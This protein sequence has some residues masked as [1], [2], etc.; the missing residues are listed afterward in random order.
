MF[1]KKIVDLSLVI[2]NHTPIYPGDPEPRLSVATTIAGEGYNLHHVHIGSQTGSHVDAPYHFLDSG[3]RI[4]EMD[5][6]AFV[7]PGLLIPAL[8]KSEQEPITLADVGDYVEQA[9]A[10]QIVLFHTGWSAYAGQEKYFRHPYVH[11]EVIQALLAKGVRTFCIDCINMDITGGSEFPVHDAVAAV[12]GV[13]AENLTNF[14]AIDF[15]DPF[16][17]ILPLKLAGCDGAPVRAVAMQLFG[18]G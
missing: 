2:D 4:D 17:S 7:G 5:L 3:Q 6:K 9:Q 15:P 12:S 1:P 14:A 8:G 16:I 13:I 18:H 10:G 11:I